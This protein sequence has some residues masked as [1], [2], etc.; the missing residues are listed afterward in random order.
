MLMG[1]SLYFYLLCGYGCLCGLRVLENVHP[2]CL[3][4]TFVCVVET[5][6]C[7]QWNDFRQLNESWTS[8]LS[9]MYGYVCLL[10]ESAFP[11]I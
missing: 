10:A 7:Q 8:S 11:V 5:E 2:L 9:P 3:S 1:I 6:E 4:L